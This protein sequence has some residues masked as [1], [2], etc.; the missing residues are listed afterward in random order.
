VA[1]VATTI[2]PAAVGA[3]SAAVAP[4]QLATASS[5]SAA[6]GP[7]DSLDDKLA[8]LL[9]PMVRQWLDDNMLRALEKAVSIEVAEGAL[10]ALQ[11]LDPGQKK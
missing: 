9:R 2:Q 5:G 4:A 11:K 7:T 8:E 6:T 3:A 1:P 10:T